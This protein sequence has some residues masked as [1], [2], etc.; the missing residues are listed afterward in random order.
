MA[1]IASSTERLRVEDLQD[2]E[3]SL[4]E[5]RA[6]LIDDVLGLAREAAESAGKGSAHHTHP[7]DLATDSIDQD[8][9]LGR[10]ESA[11]D[12]IR[13]IDDA[14]A[15]LLEGYYGL[16]EEC[17]TPLPQARL[18]AIPYARLC[19]RCKANQEAR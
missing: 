10:M 3:K 14:L 16:C 11:G 17:N 12:E 13:E 6:F 2:F 15:R 7:A 5:R 8:V 19:I 9:R 4:R 1:M 18:L